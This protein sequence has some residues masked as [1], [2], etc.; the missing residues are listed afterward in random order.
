[1]RL[2]RYRPIAILLLALHLGG[3]TRWE[4]TTVSP[5][6]L[7]EEERPSAVRVT[8]ADG[9]RVELDDP[10]IRADSISMPREDCE[11]AFTS[12]GRAA[13]VGVTS[14]ALDDVQA[15]DLRRPDAVRTVAALVLG[16]VVFLGAVLGVIC[17]LG[18]GCGPW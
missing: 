3:C 1:M 16:P 11:R 10:L 17:G 2:R 7:I 13:C 12:D 14:V 5:R 9:T 6:V 4:P 8:R 15:L 18:D